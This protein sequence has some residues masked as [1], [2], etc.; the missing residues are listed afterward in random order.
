METIEATGWSRRGRVVTA[1][2]AVVVLTGLAAGRHLGHDSEADPAARPNA[3]PSRPAT[4]RPSATVRPSSSATRGRPSK[5][6]SLIPPTRTRGGSG[7]DAEVLMPVTFPDGSTAR[8]RCPR[9]LGIARLRVRPGI[10]ARYGNR[11][12][13]WLFLPPGGEQ[14]L[15]DGGATRLRTL[16]GPRDGRGGPVT[17]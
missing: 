2:A 11:P 1:V 13:R 15:V 9:R 8:V 12:V 16:P 3:S 4:A 5:M 7:G 6:N 14:W 17:V 10:G